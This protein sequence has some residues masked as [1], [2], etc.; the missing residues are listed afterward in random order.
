[1]L[2][3]EKLQSYVESLAKAVIWQRTITST[4]LT[5][6]DLSFFVSLFLPTHNLHTA[7]PFKKPLAQE[8]SKSS[9]AQT[10]HSTVLD[11]VIEEGNQ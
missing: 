11:A 4:V 2:A 6:E 7:G 5:Y 8:V 1:M 9:N 3:P 10:S